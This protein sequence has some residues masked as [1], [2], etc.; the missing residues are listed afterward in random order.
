MLHH[1]RTPTSRKRL[2]AAL[3]LLAVALP[4]RAE[5]QKPDSSLGLIPADAAF[6]SATLRNREQFDAVANSKTWA[7]ITKLPFYQMAV[8]HFKKQYEE[9]D[10][11]FL[12][13]FRQWMK[14]PE[15][16][17]LV[18]LLTDAVSTEIFCYGGSN[19][20]D[21]LDLMQKISAGRYGE[22][23]QLLMG[24]QVKDHEAI[25]YATL[26][27]VLRALAENRNKIKFPDLVLGF[28]IKDAKKADAQIKRLEKLMLAEAGDLQ[29]L[30]PRIKRVKVGD[31]RFLTLFLDGSM[32][33]WDQI[34]WQDLEEEAG[35]FD[36][37]RKRLKKIKLTISLGVRGDFLLFSIGSTTEGIKNL[38]GAGPR[39]SSL[40]E[41]KPL[42][43]AAGKRLTGISYSSKAWAAQMSTTAEDIDNLAALARQFLAV[44]DIPE[45]RRKA[46]RKDLSALA[47]EI[48]KNLTAPSASLSF[49]YLTP[50]GYE[51]YD[52]QYGEFPDRDSSQ[53]LTLLNHVGRDP[54]LAIVG[55]SKGRLQR[56]QTLS[57]WLQIAYGHLEAVVLEQ[58]DEAEKQSSPHRR[59]TTQPFLLKHK[60]RTA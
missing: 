42:L 3:L 27:G 2:L 45:Q 11:P 44:D 30:Q 58:L 55:R 56:Y 57:K 9:G 48:K 12:A 25:N 17:D 54:I 23:I 53:A 26:R 37:L 34:D 15:N 60:D 18:D 6:Y 7:R 16:R 29:K 51:S 36:G 24:S 10:D 41:L 46:I 50:R 52:Y 40:P 43:R 31:S 35:E 4:V 33:P 32:V 39:L 20:I 22:L 1:E 28:K 5:N 8:Q 21:F 38:G 14:Q 59:G 19:W 47:G 13:S 49:S